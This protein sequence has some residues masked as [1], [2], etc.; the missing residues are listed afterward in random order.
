[1]DNTNDVVIYGIVYDKNLRDAREVS[2]SKG[3]GFDVNKYKIV[4]LLNK[5]LIK[6]YK[7]NE[8]ISQW[9]LKNYT[10]KTG[11]TLKKGIDYIIEDQYQ[12]ANFV[13]EDDTDFITVRMSPVVFPM[14]GKLIFEQINVEDPVVIKGKMGS[15]IRMFFANHVLSLRAYKKSLTNKEKRV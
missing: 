5:E 15:G 3:K 8:W 9:A 7:G 4:H 10:D 1:M 13:V 2:L 12:F 11:N 14:Y 6:W